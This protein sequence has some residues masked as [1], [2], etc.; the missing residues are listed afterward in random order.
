MACGPSAAPKYVASTV[1]PEFVGQLH[2]PA[3]PVASAPPRVQLVVSA[4]PEHTGGEFALS[5][6]M[7]QVALHNRGREPVLVPP[8]GIDMLLSLQVVLSTPTAVE[9]RRVTLDKPWNVAVQPLAPESVVHQSLSPLSREQR[10]VPL[11]PGRY[12]VGVCVIP[13]REAAYHS[14]FTAQLGGTCSNEIELVVRRGK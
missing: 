9:F 8:P 4:M 1:P 11:A 6:P 3:A 10:D 5:V 14:V 13:D 7:L 2:Q 12:Q